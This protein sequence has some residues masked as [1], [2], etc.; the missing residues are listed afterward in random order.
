MWKLLSLALAEAFQVRWWG[1]QDFLK[2]EP[3]VRNK[4]FGSQKV[5]TT[6]RIL[7]GHA[8]MPRVLKKGIFYREEYDLAITYL[9]GLRQ[10]QSR[11]YGTN[12]ICGQ[13]GIGKSWVGL[14]TDADAYTLGKSVF[15]YVLLVH[16]LRKKEVVLFENAIQQVFLFTGDC[17]R[18]V[19]RDISYLEIEDVAPPGTCALVDA[20]ADFTTP[21]MIFRGDTSLFTVLASSPRE[22]HWHGWIKETR[23]NADWFM[24]PW[25]WQEIVQACVCTT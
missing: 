12:I 17:V 14:E 22:S 3:V 18:F 5:P 2:E 9:E 24:M 19:K 8:F 16:L 6:R 15:L 20:G 11:N 4:P 10:S 13:P 1:A 25:T 21:A 23:R 7:E